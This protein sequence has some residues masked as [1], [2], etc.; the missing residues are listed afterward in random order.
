[1]MQGNVN[2]RLEA[3]VGLELIGP[4]RRCR[5]DVVIDTGF[6]GTLSLESEVIRE[7]DLRRNGTREGTLADGTVVEFDAYLGEVVWHRADR[8][9]T[10]LESAG[11]NLLGME[12]LED[13]RLTIDVLKEG[14][15]TIQPISAT[16]PLT[17]T[18]G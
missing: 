8:T 7:M 11:G 16:G 10:V 18:T 3:V 14:R 13:S 15:L 9:V 17:E 1:M 2:D 12:L 5:I 4:A 6:N